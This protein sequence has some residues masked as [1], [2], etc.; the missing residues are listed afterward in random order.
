MP[1]LDCWC[2][3]PESILRH[4]WASQNMRRRS[5]VG[6]GVEFTDRC[7]QAGYVVYGA[8][9]GLR[10]ACG[11][12]ACAYRLVVCWDVARPL[13]EGQSVIRHRGLDVGER[14]CL[15]TGARRVRAK[16][17]QEF[18][19]GY[20]VQSTKWMHVKTRSDIRRH[21]GREFSVAKE[22]TPH[23]T[24]SSTP[25]LAPTTPTIRSEPPTPPH[26]PLAVGP[27]WL[28]GAHA[29]TSYEPASQAARPEH[30][31][32]GERREGGGAGLCYLSPHAPPAGA[33]EVLLGRWRGQGLD[34]ETSQ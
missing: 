12:D 28:A 26:R 8:G 6:S 20:K 32:N 15:S 4:P 29:A 33:R 23:T 19:Q 24:D 2:L 25:K 13:G 31:T 11:G 30:G 16:P 1:S 22:E 34:V 7:V 17:T 18:F 3:A 9:K 21:A 14:H 27:L 5:V 10:C